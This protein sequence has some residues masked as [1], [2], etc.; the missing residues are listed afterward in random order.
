[1]RTRNCRVE[2]L[3]V[4]ALLAGGRPAPAAEPALGSADF[5]PSPHQPVGWRG[6]GTG[7]YPG[8]D[9][10]T[11]WDIERGINVLWR[12]PTKQYA[13]STPIV[14][15]DK[16]LTTME[17]R[18]LVCLDKMTGRILWAAN[19]GAGEPV[20]DPAKLRQL[21]V[22]DEGAAEAPWSQRKMGYGQHSGQTMPTPVSDGR[23]VWVK[24][25]NLAAC[26]DL[27]GNRKWAADTHLQNTDHPQNVAS[28]VLAVCPDG[29]AVF[30]CDGGATPYWLEGSK[31]KLP[32]GVMPPNKNPRA[33]HW[34]VG[35]D[36]ATGEIAWDLGPM[37]AGGYHMGSSP[38]VVGIGGGRQ[39]RSFILTGEGQVIRP[40]D[41]K[42]VLPYVGARC[43]TPSPY[44]LGGHVLFNHVF[45]LTLVDLTMPLPGKV[46]AQ[47]LWHAPNAKVICGSV[48][49]DG[50]IYILSIWLP[51]RNSQW[52]NVHDVRTGQRV[53]LDR[54]PIDLPRDG[55][56][57]PC[58]VVGGKYVFLLTSATAAVIEPGRRPRCLA[59]NTFERTHA[60]PAFDGERMYLRT[61]DA[62]ACIA[63]KGEEGARYERLV[64]ARTL[65][66][67][68]PQ[69]LAKA[70]L[71]AIAPPKDFQPPRG[72]PTA[73]LD[74]AH[75][76]PQWLFAG[77]LPLQADADLLQAVG[78]PGACP[79][80]GTAVAVGDVTR[81]VDPLNRQFARG[82]RLDVQAALLGR[83]GVQ[84]LFWTVVKA[85]EPTV[86]VNEAPGPDVRLFVGGRQVQPGCVMQLQPGSYPVC[87]HAVVRAEAGAPTGAPIDV[88]FRKVPLPAEQYKKD[89]ATVRGGRDVLKRVMDLAPGTDY[90]KRAEALLKAAQ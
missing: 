77:P 38:I 51:P 31:N 55:A 69:R 60:A 74:E 11:A 70:A 23:H 16:L 90:A 1:M 10:V 2:L 76:S 24:F 17:P 41:G 81:K 75:T 62:I 28:P 40:A 8:A 42:L 71:L 12:V 50:L 9:P 25:G 45:S 33:Q 21:I 73:Q 65:L 36:A 49:H 56:D 88:S 5:G 63:R 78:G 86:V 67:G 57:Y 34:M 3:I 37:N 47:T 85:A 66:A 58:P 32:K 53:F 22:A 14:V 52:I 39:R 44:V 19:G 46:Q 59:V 20:R 89:L 27:D 4:A 26:Y 72:A 87:L 35:L 79:A 68:F 80:R 61:Y 48:Y 7:R 15:G 82:A 64:Q 29:R 18:W 54:L 84:G 83:R 30:A 43:G 6:D 13:C